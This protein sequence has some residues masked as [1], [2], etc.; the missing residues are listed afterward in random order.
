MK[1]A[2]ILASLLS[3]QLYSFVSDAQ[4]VIDC[5]QCVKFPQNWKPYNCGFW[6]ICD[7]C[8]RSHR[9][10]NAFNSTLSEFFISSL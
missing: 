6:F 5:S 4:A 2:Y 3:V 1:T 9:T 10:S 8:V 7:N